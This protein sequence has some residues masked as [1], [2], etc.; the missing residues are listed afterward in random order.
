MIGIQVKDKVTLAATG[1]NNVQNLSGML[2][3]Q[4]EMLECLFQVTFWH[5]YPP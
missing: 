2:E 3:T 1:R 5:P 4:S